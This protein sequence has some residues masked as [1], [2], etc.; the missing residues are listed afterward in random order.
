[1]GSKGSGTEDS[2]TGCSR[3]HGGPDVLALCVFLWD[4]VQKQELLGHMLGAAGDREA[5]LALAYALRQSV[6]LLALVK[7]RLPC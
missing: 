2:R 3:P 1:M 6:Q 4:C 7:D 5:L